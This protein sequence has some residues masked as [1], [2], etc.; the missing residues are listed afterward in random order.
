[1]PAYLLK[2]LL[3]T[4]LVLFGIAFVVFMI[5]HMVPGDPVR[6][7]LGLQ[8]DQEKVELI[9]RQLG[10]DRPLLVQ[11]GKWLWS[12]LQG[13]LGFSILTGEKV[14]QAVL[15]RLPATMTLAVASLLIAL[16]IALPTGII[17]ALY[18]GRA[19]DYAAALFS[20]IG[21]SIP[22]FWMGIMLILVFSLFLG[23]LPPSGYT[24]LS[25]EP[26]MWL[27]HLILPS[28]TVGVI[29]ASILTR[30]IRSAV[31]EVL[32]EDYVRAARAKGMRER[33][34]ILRHVLRNAAIPIVTAVGMQLASLLSGVIVVEIIFAWPGLG[35][36][37]LD[38]VTR[39]DYPMVQGAVL[40]VAFTFT[41][42][43]L[44]VDILY[45]FLDPR[46]KYS[47]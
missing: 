45:T 47:E 46:I 3:T 16:V 31:I 7:M 17:S 5:I 21:M 43:N 29:T 35:R 10:Y 12:A 33:R 34:V 2:R 9:R 19:W 30:F 23:W 32:H 22:D 39:R 13:D 1:M 41:L 36:L 20:Q 18:P 26:L 42:I 44:F 8:A 6:I 15:Q 14:T 38:S 40:L 11:F 28:L 24:D 4:L 27:K 37:T 25:T